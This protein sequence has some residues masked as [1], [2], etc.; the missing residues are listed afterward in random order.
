MW[1]LIL[2]TVTKTY[3]ALYIPSLVM[4]T[5]PLI[6]PHYAGMG[7]YIDDSEYLSGVGVANNSIVVPR[8]SSCTN[9]KLDIYCCTDRAG[10]Q[11]EFVFPDGIRKTTTNDY[12]NMEVEQL[13]GTARVRAFNHLS[14]YPQIYGLYCCN[15][16][17]PA[18]TSSVAVYSSLPGNSPPSL[19]HT[20]MHTH[21]WR[22]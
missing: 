7:L 21:Q 12:Y 11:M 17:S 16:G 3:W 6:P 9:C 4:V 22:I 1:Q 14:Y 19:T 15:V 20:H 10:L 18:L 13:T 5:F 2:G 8:S